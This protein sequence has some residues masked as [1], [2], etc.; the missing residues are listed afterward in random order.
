MQLPDCDFSHIEANGTL[1]SQAN[2]ERSLFRSAQLRGAKFNGARLR[3]ANLSQADLEF[4]YM[5]GAADVRFPRRIPVV[6]GGD[7]GPPLHV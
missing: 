6:L 1:F 4:A 3:S 2:L 7:P 5:T